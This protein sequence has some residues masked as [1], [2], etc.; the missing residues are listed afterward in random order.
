MCDAKLRSDAEAFVKRG[1]SASKKAWYHAPDWG[2]AA[3]HYTKAGDGFFKLEMLEQAKDAYEKAAIAYDNENLQA[4]SGELLARAA[5]AAFLLLQ[6]EEGLRL[7]QTAKVRYLEGNQAIAA[8]RQ[9]RDA[10]QR[11]RESEPRVA[12][13]LYSQLLEVVEN[14]EMYHWEKESFIDYAMLCLEL[15]DYDACFAAWGRAKK[16][17]LFLKNP[18]AAAHCVCSAI[19]I[20]LQRGDVVAAE[21]LFGEEMQ[22]DYFIQTDDISMIDY[23]VRGVKNHDGDILELGQKHFVLP[24][25]KPEISRIICSFNA[26]RA[27][28]PEGD[29]KRFE[30]GKAQ[31]DEEGGGDEEMYAEDDGARW[32]L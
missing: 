10:A 17:F 24:F 18:D 16:A 31:V 12:C 2:E 23:V 32:L 14:E 21:H 27:T 13:E 4:K 8:V 15:E 26:P 28:P 20:H 11:L 1:D 29:R 7:L 19:A 3:S 30:A 25:L 22:E 5:R 9:M 6:P